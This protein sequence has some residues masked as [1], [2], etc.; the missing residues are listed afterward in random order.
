[1]N[2]E[3]LPCLDEM[4]IDEFE[5]VIWTADG[6][7][8]RIYGRRLEDGIKT[9]RFYREAPG[10]DTVATWLARCVKPLVGDLDVEV[11]AGD[12]AVPHGNTKLAKLRASY[13][14]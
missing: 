2:A 9:Y 5:A 11:I 14:Q 6:V 13:N 8:M 7:R 12:G 3:Y 1:M 4:S 10:T